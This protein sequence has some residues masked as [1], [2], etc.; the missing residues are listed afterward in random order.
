M[1]IPGLQRGMVAVSR[2]R[3][4]PILAMAF[5]ISGL[6]LWLFFEWLAGMAAWSGQGEG[7]LPPIFI[8]GL[9]KYCG[10]VCRRDAIAQIYNSWPLMDGRF[11]PSGYWVSKAGVRH[12][13][14]NAQRS[15]FQSP[16][17]ALRL[18]RLFVVLALSIAQRM[19]RALSFVL[20]RFCCA[21]QI[22]FSVSGTCLAVAPPEPRLV[23]SRLV[24]S[25][26]YLDDVAPFIDGKTGNKIPF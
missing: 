26:L 22:W 16:C 1:V 25:R 8:A 20:D 18:T 10:A 14:E 15:K 4:A 19:L 11:V 12:L 3:L 24:R 5:I 23:A 2:Y 7:W 13:F 9:C 17:A 21:G 6:S